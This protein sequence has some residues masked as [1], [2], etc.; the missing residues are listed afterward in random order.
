MS[1]I[2]YA[3]YKLLDWIDPEDLDWVVLS[4]N[5]KVVQLWTQKIK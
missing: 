3:P 4:A 1:T 5:P 2:D